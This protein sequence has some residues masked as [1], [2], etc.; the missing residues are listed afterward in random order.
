[1]R[2][3]AY[4]R[5]WFGRAEEQMDVAS[6]GP[7]RLL[8]DLLDHDTPPWDEDSVPPL[9]HWLY[10][11]PSARQSLLD[12][13]GHP[14]RGDFLPPIA[15]PRR[16]WASGRINFFSAV[17]FGA[18]IRRRSK[19]KMIQDKSG[20][21]GKLT[22]VTL[23]H[24]VMEGSEVLLQEEQDVVFREAA[25]PA[26]A[27][28]V[29]AVGPVEPDG[30]GR[31]HAFDARQ[32]FRY[33]ALTFNSHRIHYDRTYATEVESYPDLVV[34]G[35]YMAMLL[36]DHFLRTFPR[37]A[38]REFRFRA[39]AASYSGETIRLL[40]NGSSGEFELTAIGADGRP[41]MRAKINV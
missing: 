37:T 33:S 13:D 32:L 8:A 15:L 10:F 22:F 16:M 19:I 18:N 17:P 39:V 29:S 28:P 14:Q 40:L 34:Q 9:G 2:A 7:I 5:P 30:V 27:S 26:G 38:V 21:S 12:I 1:M 41:R 23:L 4:Y 3:S 25:S 36:M 20:R 6:P 31:D 35:P 11:L 24:E